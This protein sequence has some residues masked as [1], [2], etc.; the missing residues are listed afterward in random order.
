M[1]KNEVFDIYRSCIMNTYTRSPVVFVK[2]KGSYLWDIDGKKY[3]DLFPGWAVSVL[4]HCP[5]PL[6]NALRYQASRLVHL[7]NNFYHIQQA[8]LAKELCY[9]VPFESRVFFCNSGAEA[10]EG[11]L[12][13]ARAWGSSRGKNKII[14]MNN[15]FHGRTMGALTLTGQRSYQKGFDPLLP[16]VDIVD[17]NDIKALDGRIDDKTC[18]IILELVQGEGG[19][20]VAKKEYVEQLR[21]LCDINDVLLIFDEVQTGI[22]R[23]GHWFCFEHYGVEPDIFTLAKGLGGGVPIGAVVARAEVASAF[24]PGMHA[25]TFG[26][27]PIVSRASFSVLKEVQRKK[28]LSRVRRLSDECMGIFQKWKEKWPDKIK[29]VRGIGFMF[30]LELSVECKPVVE[31]AMEN[32]LLI[33]CTHKYVLRVM[34]A[35]NVPEK[36]LFKGLDI[37]EE[38][39]DETFSIS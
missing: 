33:N 39:L 21:K 35:L 10:V 8:K 11:A 16:M 4:G 31:K 37:L 17:F 24:S 1:K 5:S 29:D 23:C 36:V 19:V 3:I 18:A 28:L 15:S 9:R 12:K 32:G 20:N 6:V 13:L 30:G 26:G 14:A 2:G 34:P 27:S 38:V 22:G 7:P 25:T